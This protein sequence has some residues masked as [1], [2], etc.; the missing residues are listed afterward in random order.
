MTLLLGRVE[1]GKK[2]HE[3]GGTATRRDMLRSPARS[4]SGNGMLIFSTGGS[5]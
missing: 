1:T 5:M 2:D 4:A 3:W